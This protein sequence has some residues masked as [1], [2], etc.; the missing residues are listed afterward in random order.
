MDEA[1]NLISDMLFAPHSAACGA[2][3]AAS[4]VHCNVYLA[5]VAASELFK[6]EPVNSGNYIPLS[7]I[8]IRCFILVGWCIK[9]ESN[10]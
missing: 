5:E 9:M 6:I 7:N 1:L 4:G 3:L 8:Y 2:L 10:D